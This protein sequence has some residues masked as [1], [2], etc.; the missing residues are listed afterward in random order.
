MN[1]T[2]VSNL[3]AFYTINSGDSLL[4]G[5]GNI[6]DDYNPNDRGGNTGTIEFNSGTDIF[7]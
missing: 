5:T 4:S 7:P 6:A 3:P 2:T 1:N